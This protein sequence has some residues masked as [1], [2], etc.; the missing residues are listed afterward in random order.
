MPRLM[1]VGF[2]SAILLALICALVYALNERSGVAE[3]TLSEVDTIVGVDA[4]PTGANTATSLG[5]INSCISVDS[6][7]VFYIDL[8]IQDVTNL[9]SWEGTFRFD[10]SVLEVNSLAVDGFF[11]GSSLW[12]PTFYCYEDPVGDE[13][14]CTLG[15]FDTT[16]AGHDNSGVLGRL[17]LTAIGTGISKANLDLRSDGL[18]VSGVIL[19]DDGDPPAAIGDFEGD[20]GF[21]DGTILNAE[22]AI[23]QP[24]P[25]ECLPDVDTDGDGFDDDVE[26]YLPTDPLDACPDDLSHDAWPLD[27][28]NNTL[29]NLVGDVTNFVGK[30]GCD[31]AINS[32]CQRLDLNADGVINLVGDLTQYVGHIGDTCS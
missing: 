26:C 24:C 20:D 2:G 4:N 12:G 28:D 21:F 25:G 14:E 22:I 18:P 31:L 3:A 8:F 30:I 23:D 1:W 10:E 16:G 7:D 13:G 19:L 27:I 9:N 29:V 32:E 6:S 15:T 5:T 17:E 11:L